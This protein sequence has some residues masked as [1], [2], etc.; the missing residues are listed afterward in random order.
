M[1]MFRMKVRLLSNLHKA[2]SAFK[3]KQTI[4][5]SNNYMKSALV[6]YLSERDIKQIMLTN[7]AHIKDIDVVRD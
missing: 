4:L 7:E 3:S 5:K 1:A 2:T 6:E